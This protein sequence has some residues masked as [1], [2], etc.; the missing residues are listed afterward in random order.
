[1]FRLDGETKRIL[2]EF[3]GLLTY[4]GLGVALW[5]ITLSPS[6]ILVY[7]LCLFCLLLLLRYRSVNQKLTQLQS[8]LGTAGQSA[9]EL[10]KVRGLFEGMLGLWLYT[11]E[12]PTSD[13]KHHFTFLEEEYIIHGDDG[14]YNWM[15][16]GYN[17]LDEPS[18]TLTVKFSGDA[19]VDISSLVL[20]VMDNSTGQ[21]YHEKQIRAIKDFPYLKIIDIAFPKPIGKDECFDLRLSC[22]WNN[23]F[24]RSRRYDYVFF[25]FGYYAAK[26]I[27]KLLVRLVCDVPLCDFELHRLESGRLLK[28]LTQPKI[29]DRGRK[30]FT[31][32]WEISHPRHVYILKFT[33]EVD[34]MLRNGSN[35]LDNFM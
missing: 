8:T 12:L 19:P 3:A 22:R 1:M 23:T 25:P 5:Q 18:Q 30:H 27:D 11:T 16:Q 9:E 17:T 20:S 13:T 33:K 6:W 34:N 31:L 28:E 7:G 32:E 2:L 35:G 14:T 26:G 15:L 24:P 29:V 4:L 21:R 10:Q